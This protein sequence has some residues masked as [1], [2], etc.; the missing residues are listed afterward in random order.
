MPTTLE[1][2]TVAFSPGMLLAWYPE[3]RDSPH[4]LEQRLFA[5]AAD[6]RLDEFSLLDAALIASGVKDTA[7]LGRYR[8]RMAAWA[9]ELKRSGGADDS[10]RR[11]VEA[12]FTFLHGKILKGKYNIQCTDLRQAMDE[13]RFN[14]VSATVLFNCLAGE[15]GLSCCGLETPGH[16]L[17]RVFLPEGPLDVETTCPRWFCLQ[18]DRLVN[19]EEWKGTDSFLVRSYNK[20]LYPFENALTPSPSPKGRGDVLLEPLRE[21]RDSYP[22][23]ENSASRQKT[24]GQKPDK[25]KG[26]LREISPIELTAMIYYNRGIDF[27][28]EKRFADA[29]AANVKAMRLDPL[30]STAR[31][32][33]LATINNWAIDLGNAGDYGRAADLLRQGLAI[34]PHYEAFS[35]NF[36]HVHH[37][38][39]QELCREG[40]YAEAVELLN[41]A[42][43]EMP[44]NAYFQHAVWG[45][46]RY[47]AIAL[48][49]A[50]KTDQA[51]D[52]LRFI[53]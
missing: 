37:Q 3:N 48:L 39:T 33:F 15:L 35:L 49:K 8:D 27:L 41:Q 4:D 32:N 23:S 46:Y 38:W 22:L 11:R 30:S 36:A 29:A 50:N 19:N 20:T 17:S 42:A 24:I 6:G 13:G 44:D 7:E 43:S 25:D 10:P 31:G 14:C 9:G 34:E 51:F 45:V 2:G 1:K 53:N 52:I 5:D 47:W 12:I 28:G 18:H 16:A 26:K 40:K 21:N